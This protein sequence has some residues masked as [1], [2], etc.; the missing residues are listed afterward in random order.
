MLVLGGYIVG[1]KD[2]PFTAEES[3]IFGHHGPDGTNYVFLP[4]IYQG[5]CDLRV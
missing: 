1:R 2:R 4:A 5:I 3:C